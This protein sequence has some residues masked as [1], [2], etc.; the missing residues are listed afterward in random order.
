M[1]GVSAGAL[2]PLL[3]LLV[4]LASDAW[5]YVD[6]TAQ[7]SRGTPIVFS[8]GPLILETPSAWFLASLV[9]WIVFFPL[10]LAGRRNRVG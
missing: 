3:V 1:S 4:V 7:E 8:S 2:A 9:V 10:Y 5:V 6:A